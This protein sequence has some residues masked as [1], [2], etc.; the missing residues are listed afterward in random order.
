MKES[1][2]LYQSIKLLIGLIKDLFAKTP[3]LFL[4]CIMLIYLLMDIYISKGFSII[5]LI[6]IF[7]L[8]TS[9]CIYIKTNKISD[10][11]LSFILGILTVYSIDW[12]K[13]N[14]KLFIALYTIYII[15]IFYCY[16]IR[17]TIKQESILVQAACKI[18]LEN[19]KETYKKLKKL[20]L[21]STDYNMLSI[22]DRCEVI[23]YL[24]FRRVN[25]EEYKESIK[26][27]EIIKCACQIDLMKCC[28]IY[29]S[30]F[31]YC[32]NQNNIPLAVGKMIDKVTTLAISYEEFFNI[33]KETKYIISNETVTFDR[34][35]EII[36]NMSIR[37]YG[38]KDII[39]KLKKEEL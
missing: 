25:I 33:F 11:T 30:M 21:T 4:A 20:S 32:K 36:Q 37:G 8:L 10:T 17:L 35:L 31:I 2:S 18:N 34:Y 12:E 23:R 38:Y 1:Y 39:S 16:A 27:I 28:E 19:Y 22:L 9:L 7:I 13:A 14:S 6:G 15:I 29:Y 5:F 24:A 26:V 3:S